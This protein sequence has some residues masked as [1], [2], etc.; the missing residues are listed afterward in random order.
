[1]PGSGFRI[2]VSGYCRALNKLYRAVPEYRI[3][4]SHVGE[5]SMN[6]VKLLVLISGVFL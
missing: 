1:M 3:N 5:D 6:S 2:R 4:T